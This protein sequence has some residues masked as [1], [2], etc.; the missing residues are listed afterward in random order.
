MR[1][2]VVFSI[3]VASC[4]ISSI[5]YAQAGTTVTNQGLG[6]PRSTT[7][8]CTRDNKGQLYYD[9]G[10]CVSL[11]EFFTNPN[12]S[13]KG[14]GLELMQRL[15][16]MNSSDDRVRQRARL[17]RDKDGNEPYISISDVFAAPERP[18]QPPDDNHCKNAEKVN[19]NFDSFAQVLINWIA[20]VVEKNSSW[21]VEQ[22]NALGEG[23]LPAKME[24]M[25]NPEFECGCNVTNSEANNAGAAFK[26]PSPGPKNGH[27]NIMCK[28]YQML[29]YAEKDQTLIGEETAPSGKKPLKARPV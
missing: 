27:H 25:D 26:G 5:A 7:G 18:G 9:S 20:A 16:A 13:P 21:Q 11:I 12:K 3:F 2:L 29:Y 24:E 14:C 15:Y 8:L 17:K 23:L 10:Y 1:M 6:N 4:G 19:E 22:S 28:A